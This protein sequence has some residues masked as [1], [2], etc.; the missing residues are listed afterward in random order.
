MGMMHARCCCRQR[1]SCGCSRIVLTC[2][3]RLAP[4]RMGHPSCAPLRRLLLLLQDGFT[5]LHLTAHRSK[6]FAPPHPA[7]PG[8][9]FTTV[10][11]ARTH[12]FTTMQLAT[13][14]NEVSE[15]AGQLLAAGAAVD[16]VNKVSSF[17][18]VV[19][20]TLS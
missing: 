6:Q 13:L 14:S 8:S 19:H 16:A 3:A 20:S 18:A 10:S 9:E 17:P 7:T 4:A 2:V 12:E 15:V 5:P 1:S 11:G